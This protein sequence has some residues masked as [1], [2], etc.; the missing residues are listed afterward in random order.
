MIWTLDSSNLGWLTQARNELLSLAAIADQVIRG[1]PDGL[2]D[3]PM[4]KVDINAATGLWVWLS[5]STD[6]F[7]RL[8]RRG[9]FLE[10][11]VGE[12]VYPGGHAVPYL[13]DSINQYV[14]TPL[15]R[16]HRFCLFVYQ[17][18]L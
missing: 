14:P 1:T 10:K 9:D 17:V 5:V 13:A 3:T 4:F 18:D 2:E 7:H 6:Q 15:A 12:K 16:W 8:R 11:P